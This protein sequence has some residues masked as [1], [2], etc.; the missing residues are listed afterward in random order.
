MPP[1]RYKKP[2]PLRKET[3]MLYKTIV[4][5]LLE[6]RPQ[7]HE[8]LRKERRLL[9]TLETYAKELKDSHESWIGILQ[10]EA[11]ERTREQVSAEAFELALNELTDRLPPESPQAGQEELSLN[12]AMAHI[13]TPSLRG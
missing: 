9:T 13:R 1:A 7:M 10:Q 8:A 12:Q 6:N 5:H 4:Q 3:T 2:K 11:S